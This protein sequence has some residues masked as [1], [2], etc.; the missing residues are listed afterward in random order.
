[1]KVR[2]KQRNSAQ[3]KEAWGIGQPGA[4][5]TG[6]FDS[7]GSP[8]WGPLARK[9]I[10]GTW[11]KWHIGVLWTCLATC[12][13]FKKKKNYTYHL[14]L[15]DLWGLPSIAS[16]L[17]KLWLFRL[18]ESLY[19]S[20]SAL[21]WSSWIP[22]WALLISI[23]LE[24]SPECRK[25]SEDICRINVLGSSLPQRLAGLS[26]DMPMVGKYLQILGSSTPLCKPQS[27]CPPCSNE[28]CVLDSS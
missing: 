8:T 2:E 21:D 14:F 25:H 19:C 17:C 22:G 23:S 24:L 26:W 1:M 16:G 20:A 27:I 28:P 15:E 6:G 11:G 12:L 3:E 4:L 7:W 9:D 13:K 5:I 18:K 10:G